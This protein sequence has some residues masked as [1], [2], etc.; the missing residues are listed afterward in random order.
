MSTTKLQSFPREG[1]LL[2]KSSAGYE[3]DENSDLWQLD[4]S[5]KV[6]IGFLADLDVEEKTIEGFRKALSRYAQELSS[7]TTFNIV[8]RAKHFFGTTLAKEISAKALSTYL[9]TLDDDNEWYLGMLRGFFD[10]WYEWGFPGISKEVFRYLDDLTIRGNKKGIAVLMRCPY[11]GPYTQ[12]EQQSLLFGLANAYEERRL[13]Q[14][15]YSFLLAICMTGRRP[16]Q[17]RYL[18]SGDLGFTESNGGHDYYLDIPRA[19]QRGGASFRA[20]IKRIPICKDLYDALQD[21]RKI[22]IDWVEQHVGKIGKDIEAQL[23]LFPEYERFLGRTSRDLEHLLPTDYLHITKDTA[24]AVRMKL[25]AQVVAYCERTGDRLIIGFTR[26]RRTF[27]NNL[28]AE[29]FGPMVIA[30]ALDHS[31]TQQV[32][33]YARPYK[34]TAEVIDELMAPIMAPLAMAF[35]GI[36]VDAERDAVRGN[37]PHSRVKLNTASQV[38]SCGESA[39]CAD[40]WKSC[41]V[42]RKFQPWLNGPHE[43]AREELLRE[44]QIQ[45]QAKVSDQVIRASDRVLVAIEQVI[46]MCAARK[47]ELNAMAGELHE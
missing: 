3:F 1:R 5:I 22:V 18:K 41:Y 13:N 21:Q 33:V 8:G 14:D 45:K 11:S 38:G 17:I 12:L 16:V 26:L 42:C 29:G 24:N 34:E 27:A 4:G 28:G 43:K 36:L 6:N 40:G 39:F 9:S 47:A 25:N 35:A 15:E 2:R 7:S 20:E 37:D 23:P 31:D 46:Q 44:R 19:K 30:E 10:S 32:A